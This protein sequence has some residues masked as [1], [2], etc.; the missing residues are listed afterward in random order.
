MQYTQDFA[1]RLE[2][3]IPS[4]RAPV[5]PT[6][7][8]REGYEWLYVISGQLRLV[9]ADHDLVLRA[10]EAAEI[11]SRLPHWFDRFGSEP[12]ELP[13]LFGARRAPAR[14]RLPARLVNARQCQEA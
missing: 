4:T 12:V 8:V 13:R 10:G 5:V 2:G 6:Q 1:A 7:Q 11:D 14:P 9:L 3:T